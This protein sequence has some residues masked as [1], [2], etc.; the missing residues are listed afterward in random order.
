MLISRPGRMCNKYFASSASRY[1]LL[2]FKYL[3]IGRE[4]EGVL[5]EAD[6][7]LLLA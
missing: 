5:R 7:N 6:L 3:N 4:F 1:L 2:P